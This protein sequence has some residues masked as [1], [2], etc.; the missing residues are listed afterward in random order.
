MLGRESLPELAMS[1]KNPGA[2][3]NILSRIQESH[4]RSEEMGVH[5]DADQILDILD[6]KTLSMNLDVYSGLINH[7]KLLF[8]QVFLSLSNRKALFVLTDARA[9]ILT[10]C[11]HLTNLNRVA[12]KGVCLGA[13]LCEKSIGTNSVSLALHDLESAIVR[14]PEHFSRLFHECYCVSVP[15]LGADGRPVGCLSISS[16]DAN[17]MELQLALLGFLAKDIVDYCIRN[18]VID[19]TSHSSA[20]QEREGSKI[21]LTVRQAQVL[22]LYSQGLSY[23]HIARQLQLQSAKTVQEHLDV[24]RVKLG[25][26][27][28]RDCIRKA[29]RNN[30]LND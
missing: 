14:G 25:A 11:S 15:I 5:R 18:A 20:V 22:E 8:S 7:A 17:S 2:K 19:T 21:R 6:C 30:L 12:Q 27:S 23:K 29:L 9:R 4:R 26:T 28:R 1:Y 10:L 3:F 16:N 13:S 24:V